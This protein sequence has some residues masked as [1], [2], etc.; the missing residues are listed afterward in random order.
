[1]SSLSP[2]ASPLVTAVTGHVGLNVTDAARSI[3]FYRRV[4]GFDLLGESTE[5][6]REYAFLGHGD[7]LV[8]TLWQQSGDRFPTA[9]PGLHHLAFNV[10]TAEDVDIAL[11]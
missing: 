9:L 11:K 1:M 7:Q 8:L 10:P 2:I 3:A 5:E 4:F 6:G